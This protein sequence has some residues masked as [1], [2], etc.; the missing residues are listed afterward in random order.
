[1][2]FEADSRKEDEEGNG[3]TDPFGCLGIVQANEG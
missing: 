2:Y 1:M 3:G